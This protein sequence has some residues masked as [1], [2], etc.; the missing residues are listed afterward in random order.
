[1]SATGIE[2]ERSPDP[3][4]RVGDLLSDL[5]ASAQ[6]IDEKFTS[7]S[8]GELRELVESIGKSIGQLEEQIRVNSQEQEDLA[9]QSQ[10]LREEIKQ[11]S[12]RIEEELAELAKTSRTL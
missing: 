8:V 5:E 6:Q 4:G 1:M 2:F 3:A 9:V 12:V 10:A 7:L 11:L